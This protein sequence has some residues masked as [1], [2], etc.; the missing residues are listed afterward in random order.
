M[1]PLALLT[2]AAAALGVALAAPGCGADSQGAHPAAPPSPA[3]ALAAPAITA[4]AADQAAIRQTALD[5]IEGWYAGDGDRMARA[6]HPDLAKRMVHADRATGKSVLDQMG[7]DKLV[8]GTRR[9]F[10]KDTPPARQQKDVTILDVFEGA[11]SVKI[12]AS[13]WIDYLHMARFDGRWVIINVLWE[14]KPGAH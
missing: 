9:G 2:L 7:A 4:S 3:P 14:L 11:A 10:G 6:L 12:V 1:K 13:D 5:Y 8:Q